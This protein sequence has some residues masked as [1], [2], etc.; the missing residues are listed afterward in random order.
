MAPSSSK[1]RLDAASGKDPLSPVDHPHQKEGPNADKSGR[2]DIEEDWLLRL[3]HADQIR[4]RA[5]G[6]PEAIDVAPID[7]RQH[8]PSLGWN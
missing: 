1:Q 8:S 6:L 5:P 7:G 2:F 3:E 4:S